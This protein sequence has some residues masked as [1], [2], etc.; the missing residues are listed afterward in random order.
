MGLESSAVEVTGIKVSIAID[1]DGTYGTPK[2]IGH[3]EDIGSLKDSSRATKK[4]TPMNDRQ[5]DEI[6][7]L[8]ASTEAALTMSVLFDPEGVEGINL[9]NDAYEENTKV[10][11]IIE[12]NNSK[13]TNG[14]TYK[15]SGKISKRVVGL[16]KEGLTKADI[17]VEK[18]GAPITTAAA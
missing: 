2:I 9:A 16:E 17:T 7:S 14:T 13:G 5:Y 3:L 11:I 1:E 8:G 6:I 4:Y 18:I 10:Q 15:Q 12:L